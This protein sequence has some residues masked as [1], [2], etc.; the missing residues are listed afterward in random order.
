MCICVCVHACTCVRDTT[1]GEYDGVCTHSTHVGVYGSAGLQQ[2]AA[3]A[4][5][6]CAEKFNAV[7]LVVE[8]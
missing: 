6:L 3:A 7:W 1:A 5:P 2:N 4:A 8:E